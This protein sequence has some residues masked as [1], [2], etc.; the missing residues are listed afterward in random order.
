[1][2]DETEL[3]E[4]LEDY[5]NAGDF[6]DDAEEE[7][8]DSIYDPSDEECNDLDALLEETV[9]DADPQLNVE[10]DLDSS[11]VTVAAEEEEVDLVI[12]NF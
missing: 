7:E 10:Y 3:K 5:E 8:E 1:M 4:A 12:G 6:L 9:E 2:E 11:N